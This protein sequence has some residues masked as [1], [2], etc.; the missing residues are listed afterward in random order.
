MEIVWESEA[1]SPV[2]NKP[3]F[4]VKQ[5]G[6]YVY[7]ERNGVD[8]I[9]FILWDGEKVGLINEHKPPLGATEFR[10]TAFGGSLDMNFAP[11]QICIQEIKEEAGYDVKTVHDLGKVLVS[12]QMN[13][14]CHLFFAD[15]TGLE[16]GERE[17]GP[18]EEG[19]ELGDCQ[20]REQ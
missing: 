14:H 16:Q 18:G 3:F 19:S 6:G 17:L 8:S 9:A 10:T 1:K 4:T 13:Q 20:C 12:T 15:V 7:G 11:R 5:E 2:N